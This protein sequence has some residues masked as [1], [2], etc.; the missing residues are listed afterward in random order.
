QGRNANRRPRVRGGAPQNERRG[1]RHEKHQNRNN[2]ERDSRVVTPRTWNARVVIR[3][4][5]AVIVVAAVAHRRLAPS[6]SPGIV[7]D[8]FQFFYRRARHG[9]ALLSLMLFPPEQRRRL[10]RRQVLRHEVNGRLRQLARRVK[11]VSS[12]IYRRSTR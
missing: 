4:A 2:R 3:L 10:F 7:N 9:L 8:D 5:I 12:A 11:F 6:A 1:K